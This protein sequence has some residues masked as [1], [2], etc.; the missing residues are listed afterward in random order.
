MLL[1]TIHIISKIDKLDNT[2][3]QVVNSLQMMKV[4]L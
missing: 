2:L 3:I 4:M 1:Q